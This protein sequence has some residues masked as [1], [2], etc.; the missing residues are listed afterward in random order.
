[1]NIE[2]YINSLKN[3]YNSL[4]EYIDSEKEEEDESYIQLKQ[5]IEDQN[6][7]EKVDDLHELLIMIDKISN[8]HHRQT[9]F[10]KKIERILLFLSTAIKQALPNYKIIDIFQF[11]KRILLILFKNKIVNVDDHFIDLITTKD[12]IIYSDNR[13]FLFN[14]IK[15]QIP[16][17]L[18][19]SI[20]SEL[21]EKDPDIF[22]D[23]DKKCEIGENHSFIC[24][25]I[26]NDS[27]EEFV[28]FINRKNYSIK[29][30]IKH[31]IFETNSFL[32]KNKNVSLIEYAAFFGS[33]QIFQY[34]R[35]NNIE[36][37]G[38]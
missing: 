33:I 12:G 9:G 7:S 19:E 20:E 27:I 29:T 34:L 8:D 1:M 35:L 10:F 2:E 28:Q 38:I 21:L 22:D 23:F 4:I 5:I 18:K 15:D 24:E 6:I 31:S 14:E 13:Y 3:I 37:R 11:N 36:L 16:N 25:L 32:L 30:M 26:R 17:S